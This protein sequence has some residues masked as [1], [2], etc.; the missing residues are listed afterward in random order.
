MHKP[1]WFREGTVVFS[2]AQT[3]GI[4][5]DGEELFVID[6]TT[7]RRTA[8]MD[9]ALRRDVQAIVTGKE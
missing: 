1:T 4:T 3:C 7:G 6:A 2:N 5:K 9:D 8:V